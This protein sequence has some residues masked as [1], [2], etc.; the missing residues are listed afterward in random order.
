MSNFPDLMGTD[1]DN[2][3]GENFWP[4]LTDIMMVVVMIFLISTA[5]LIIKNWSL[6]RDLTQT[7]ESERAAKQKIQITTAEN[8]TLEERVAALEG[9][10][11]DM[12]LREMRSKEQKAALE[13]RLDNLIS[14]LARA[15]NLSSSLEEQL[16]QKTAEIQAQLA[17]LAT[18]EKELRAARDESRLQQQSLSSLRESLDS[19]TANLASKTQEL[20]DANKIITSLKLAQK[21]QQDNLQ[22][23]RNSME[24]SEENLAKLRAQFAELE[25]KYNKLV[26]P[27]RTTKGKVIV[28]TRLRKID[29]VDEFAIKLPGSRTFQ[30][31][32]KATLHQKLAALRKQFA[33]KLYVR[34]IFPDGNGLSYQEAY[35]FTDEILRK[36]DYY[37]QEPAVAPAGK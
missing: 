13:Q 22:S 4:S 3:R 12:Q 30:T 15:N 23:A 19:T 16:Q 10:L 20:A 2:V 35:S 18:I 21:N 1:D 32:D 11:S 37:R 25:S 26:R 24:L 28:S 6:V 17:R 34:I 8:M 14:D 5:T 29:G 31:V 27:A 36:Y 7:I 9:L 33:D